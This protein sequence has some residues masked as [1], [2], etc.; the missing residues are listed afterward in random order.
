MLLLLQLQLLV[1]SSSALR[2]LPFLAPE[3]DIPAAE[4]ALAAD[5]NCPPALGKSSE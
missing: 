4:E 5:L 2:V 3:V 1:F